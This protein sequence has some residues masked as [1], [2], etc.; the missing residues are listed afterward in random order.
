MAPISYAQF[1]YPKWITKPD[2][3]KVRLPKGDQYT[4]DLMNNASKAETYVY[5]CILGKKNLCAPLDVATV[6]RKKL[7]ED[8]KKFLKV[9]KREAVE[10]KVTRELEVAATKVKLEEATAIHAIAIQA[11]YDLFC[12]LLADDPHDQWDR[13]VREVH[14]TDPWT[15][16]DGQKNKGLPM[17]TSESLEDFITFHKRTVFSLDAME[18]QKSYMMGS[19]KKPHH[20]TIKKHVS[21]CKTMNGCI[22]LLPTLRDS[23]LAVASTEKGNVPFNNATL[24]GIVL[25]TCHIDWRNL[26]KLN[27]KTVLELTR[28]MLHNLETIKKVFVEKNN[29]KAKANVAKAG[30]APQKGA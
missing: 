22:S 21:H 24:A 11:C 12:Q 29:E 9:S 15:A 18:R 1:K 19:L 10:N 20:M 4:C 6:E 2:S 7:L 14:E 8:L 30:T 3:V 17:K 5:I 26:Y 16:L 25:A 13:I 27:H 23:S 28:S